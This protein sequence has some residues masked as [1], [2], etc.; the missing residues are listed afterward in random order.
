MQRNID[1]KNVKEYVKKVNIYKK[2]YKV[3]SN[4]NVNKETNKRKKEKT[5]KTNKYREMC[6]KI[7]KNIYTNMEIYKYIEI[8]VENIYVKI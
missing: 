3:T 4:G 2:N 1:V 6:I 8:H 5:Y 7:Y